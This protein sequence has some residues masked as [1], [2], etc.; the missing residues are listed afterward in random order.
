MGLFMPIILR[1]PRSSL[2]LLILGMTLSFFDLQGMM[3]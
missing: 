3:I 1:L 2:I